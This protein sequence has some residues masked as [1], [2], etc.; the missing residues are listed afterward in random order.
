MIPDATCP[1]VPSSSWWKEG[2]EGCP[3]ATLDPDLTVQAPPPLCPLVS[4]HVQVEGL[5]TLPIHPC[6]NLTCSW[7]SCVSS[8]GCWGSRGCKAPPERVTTAGFTPPRASRSPAWLQD[9]QG[10]WAE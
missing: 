7:K 1:S 9:T 4:N 10:T 3:L 8:E 6:Y 5:P 2:G